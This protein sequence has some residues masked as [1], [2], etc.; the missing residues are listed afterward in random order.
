MF[1]FE[2]KPVSFFPTKRYEIVLSTELKG[3]G[4]RGTQS[5]GPPLRGAPT[6]REK[7]R[8][9]KKGRKMERKGKRGK[10]KKM[11]KRKD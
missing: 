3:G 9:K 7:E 6:K 10:E 8:R 1:P 4:G 5:L 11:G 2:C